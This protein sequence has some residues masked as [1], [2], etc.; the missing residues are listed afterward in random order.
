[1]KKGGY[2]A[3]VLL[4]CGFTVLAQ[5]WQWAREASGDGVAYPNGIAADTTFNNLFVGGFFAADLSDAYGSGFSDLPGGAFLAKYDYQGVVDWAI[6]I[7]GNNDEEIIDVAADASGNVYATGYFTQYANFQGNS[8]SPVEVWSTGLGSDIFIA[9]YSA[10]GE[11]LWLRTSSGNTSNDS[12]LGIHVHNNRVYVTGF[13][14]GDMMFAG[15]P[16]P[17]TSGT[18]DSFVASFS[19]TGGLQWVNAITSSSGDVRGIDI[20]ADNDHV[21]V[22]G[23]FDGDEI[24]LNDGNLILTNSQPGSQDAFIYALD[25]SSGLPEWGVAFGGA[26][27]ERINAVHPLGDN[28]IVTGRTNSANGFTPPG[29]TEISNFD[30]NDMFVFAL[31]KQTQ[32]SQWT[33]VYATSI[34]GDG[35]SGLDITVNSDNHIYLTGF[36]Q[37][38]IDFVDSTY[39]VTGSADLFLLE[40]TEGGNF[41]NLYTPEGGGTQSGRGLTRDQFD[42]IYM[43][44]LFTDQPL[45]FGSDILTGA[46]NFN[47]L[48]AKHSCFPL[49]SSVIVEDQIVCLNDDADV[50]FANQVVG[51]DGENYNYQWQVSEDEV[52]WTSIPNEDGMTY[53]PGT[54]QETLYYRVIVDAALCSSVETSISNTIEITAFP[55]PDPSWVSPVEVCEQDSIIILN[56]LI[57]GDQGGN[58]TGPFITQD[59][60]FTEGNSGTYEY[61]YTVENQYCQNSFTDEITIL[62][63]PNPSFSPVSDTVCNNQIINLEDWLEGDPGGIWSGNEVSNGELIIEDFIG[64]TE[65]TYTIEGDCPISSTQTIHVL[66]I[67]DPFWEPLEESYCEDIAQINLDEFVQGESGGSWSDADGNTYPGV[68]TFSTYGEHELTYSVGQGDCIQTHTDIVVIDEKPALALSAV[69]EVCGLE[70]DLNCNSSFD[71][72]WHSDSEVDFY[73]SAEDEFVIATVLDDGLYVFYRTVTNETCETTDS[74][75]VVFY[76]EIVSINAGEDITLYRE[77]FT[78]LDAELPDG[79]EGYWSIISG[80]GSFDES[81]APNP[82]VSGLNEGENIFE[83]TIEYGICP[84]VSDH[85][86]VEVLDIEVPTGFSPN[87]DGVN[88]DF[89]IPGITN[90]PNSE[91]VIFNRWG[92][93]MFSAKGYQNDWDGTKDGKQLPEDTYYYVLNI[94]E[95]ITLKGFIVLKR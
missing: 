32:I 41:Y 50:I 3:I 34:P 39:Q 47:I 76:E 10:S 18:E 56:D 89:V 7:G 17:P 66:D 72:V 20:S 88:D 42:N 45:D 37:S 82:F 8:A 95:E 29:G 65:V 61:T 84:S 35:S 54:V 28:L 74:I 62:P 11:L 93:Q 87:D 91:L 5:E 16:F 25:P 58:W 48:V 12:G 43:T 68:F 15:Q 51:G 49:T 9:K 30:N 33:N 94:N 77:Y 79:A 26:D 57:T 44:G 14:S 86:V 24:D 2:I 70:V 36:A 53:D 63:T 64:D 75:E 52:S 73:P 71:G 92:V 31:D 38:D 80:N 40:L 67:P 27:D 21:Y 1:M 90:F 60:I 46:N 83:W 22:A 13:Y 55:L 81:D 85:V 23:Y 59:T 69:E 6:R 19:L 78:T 4:F